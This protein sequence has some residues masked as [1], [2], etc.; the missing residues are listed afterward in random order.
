MLKVGIVG[1]GKIAEAHA[2]QIGRIE[3]CEIVAVCDR[4]PLMAKQLYERFPVKSYFSDLTQM[5]SEA[6][7]DVVH[8]CTPPENH[9]DIATTCLKAG[10]H[11][12]VEKPWMRN[13]L[14]S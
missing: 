5:L 6:K 7:P 11:V 9:F 4:E 10:T 13:R 1:C 14:E 3:G 12:Y 8:I 2:F